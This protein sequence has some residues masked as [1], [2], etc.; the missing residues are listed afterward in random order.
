MF[1][2]GEQIA[3]SIDKLATCHVFFG[4][5]F[6]A[7]KKN[8]LPVG[9]TRW[10]VF[11][12]IVNDILNTYYRPAKGY[13][14]YYHPFATSDKEQRWHPPRYGSTALQRITT[15]T[16]RDA[17]IHEKNKSEWGWVHK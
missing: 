3:R 8:D 1:F 4:T 10:V 12:T 15:D 17:L 2:S 14:G 7:F 5:S 13:E 11:S 6:L 16:F 9:S